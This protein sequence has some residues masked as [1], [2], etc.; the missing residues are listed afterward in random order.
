MSL[1]LAIM[2]MQCTDTNLIETAIATIE[3]G[4]NGDVCALLYTRNTRIR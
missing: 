1:S 3:N 2:R 4:L